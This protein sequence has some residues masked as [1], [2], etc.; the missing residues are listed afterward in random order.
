M[1]KLTVLA[2]VLFF[3][4]AGT[5]AAQDKLVHKSARLDANG[6][7]SLE[8]HN[9][10]V[11]I[12]TWSRPDVDIQA[13]VEAVYE[14]SQSDVNSTEIR[15]SGSGPSVDITTDYSAING[16]GLGIF[17]WGTTPPVH[18]TISMP[19]SAQVKVTAHNASVKVT[20][21]HNDV[22]VDTHNGPVTVADL[23]GAARIETHNGGV[24]VSYSRFGKA[25]R[26]ETHN[27]SVDVHLPQSAAFHIDAEGHHLSFDSDFPATTHGY[28]SSHYTGDVNGG[29][30]S[31]RITTH[32]GSVRVRK[33]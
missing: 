11:T 24:R 21:L 10:S 25:A 30:P 23:D 9:G 14:V 12:A 32:N 19:A 28:E 17:N 6:R 4:A 27:G 13:R 8:L 3:V 18:Y 33:S 1:R 29:G 5:Q 22:D 26:I 15:V 2:F 20:G 7:L 16:W 31:L